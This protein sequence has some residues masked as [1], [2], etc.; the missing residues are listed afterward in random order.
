M[1]LPSDTAIHLANL[2][3]IYKVYNRPADMVWEILTGRS[4]HRP[5]WALQ[6]I[7]FDVKRGQVVGLIGRN[8]AGK[9]TLPAPVGGIRWGLDGR[10]HCAVGNFCATASG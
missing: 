6:N 3:K 7:S 4:H 8:G 9:S 1:T 2:S 5:F 10:R